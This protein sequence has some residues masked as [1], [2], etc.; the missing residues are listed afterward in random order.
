MSRGRVSKGRVSRGGGE[1]GKGRVITRTAS[2]N[3]F[4]G[5][6][7]TR[8]SATSGGECWGSMGT[9]QWWTGVGGIEAGVGPALLLSPPPLPANTHIHTHLLKR[10]GLDSR[11]LEL[12]HVDGIHTRRRL[13]ACV[14]SETC[15][16]V[17]VRVCVCVSVRV[18]P[19]A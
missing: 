13:R 5:L 12:P 2:A 1:Q 8:E 15:V 4:G 9:R 11:A 17:C 6:R 14:E 19:R 7:R 16:T 18:C 10:G 3:L